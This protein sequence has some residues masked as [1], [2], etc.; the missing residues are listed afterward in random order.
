VSESAST[1]DALARL[2]DERDVI[3][4]LYAYCE[5]ADATTSD[6]FVDCF[7]E[8]GVFTY[9]AFADAEPSLTCRGRAELERWFIERLPVVPPGT[10]NHTTVH[11]RV[12]VQ[13]DQAEASSR[14]VSIRSR[15]DGLFVASTGSY[16]DRLVRGEDGRWRFAERHSIGDMPR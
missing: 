13:G 10:M 4:V 11:P 5:A 9:R 1:S 2:L 12:T 16:R 15:D 7:T 14:F 6:A 8:E 3:E